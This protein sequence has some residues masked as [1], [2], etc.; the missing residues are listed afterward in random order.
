MKIRSFTAKLAL[1]THKIRVHVRQRPEGRKRHATRRQP[2]DCLERCGCGAL[3]A[4]AVRGGSGA[5]LGH[6]VLEICLHI[7]LDYAHDL[8]LLLR[9][10]VLFTVVHLQEPLTK[11][12]KVNSFAFLI[13]SGHDVRK[14]STSKQAS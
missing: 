8:A 13:L 3:R 11:N 1:G 9:Q 14:V 4:R 6:W 10:L 12:L 7:L 5:H 2:G